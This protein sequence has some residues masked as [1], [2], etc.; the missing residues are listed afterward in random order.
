MDNK[1]I[2]KVVLCVVVVLWGAWMTGLTP[3]IQAPSLKGLTGLVGNGGGSQGCPAGTVP[4]GYRGNRLVC[5]REAVALPPLVVDA[6][7]PPMIVDAPQPVY[8]APQ[9]VV[10]APAPQQGSVIIVR[11]DEDNSGRVPSGGLLPD[12]V[13][14]RKYESLTCLQ[15]YTFT[16][17]QCLPDNPITVISTNGT[18][19]ATPIPVAATAIPVYAGATAAP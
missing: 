1:K 14:N 16:D 15:G 10:N 13:R 9:P 8:N 2:I 5:Q 19:E 17:G 4:A 12:S 18:S 3:N 6:P 7:Q 11:S